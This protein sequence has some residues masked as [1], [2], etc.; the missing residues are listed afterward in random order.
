MVA[1]AQQPASTLEETV[2]NDGSGGELLAAIIPAPPFVATGGAKADSL[3]TCKSLDL[4]TAAAL[5]FKQRVC[6]YQS[7][8]TAPSF[9]AQTTINNAFGQL[10]NEPN[11]GDKGA[12]EFG[13]RFGVYYARRAGQSTGELLAGYLN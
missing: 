5:S 4:H 9:A 1:A 13:R 8:L 6:F 10:R 11:V 12:A 3:T 7:R 2:S